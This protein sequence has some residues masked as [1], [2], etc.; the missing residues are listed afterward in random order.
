MFYMI[1]KLWV[2]RKEIYKFWYLLFSDC[3][4]PCI[5]IQLLASSSIGCQC[6]LLLSTR[7]RWTSN[8]QQLSSLPTANP[9]N[10]LQENSWNK[11]DEQCNKWMDLGNDCGQKSMRGGFREKMRLILRALFEVIEIVDFGNEECGEKWKSLHWTACI[12]LVK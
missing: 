12:K 5:L 3:T 1:I 7:Y 6:I 8:S 10:H 9:W 11:M 4:T 2:E